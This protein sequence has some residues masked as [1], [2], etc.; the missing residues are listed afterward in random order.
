M[1]L[2]PFITATLVIPFLTGTLGLSNLNQDQKKDPPARFEGIVKSVDDSNPN[3]VFLTIA[4]KE[5][6]PT[7][8][9]D[10]VVPIEKNY[11]FKVLDSAKIMG[12]DG[13]PFEG[14]LKK[15]KEGMKVR[16]ESKGEKERSTNLIE[17]LDRK[18][19]V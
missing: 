2:Q 10:E 6:R 18:S 16:V 1:I 12:M 8:R 5:M 14:G 7:T 9:E 4:V 15:L 3:S 17:V 13:K 19:V 11:Q